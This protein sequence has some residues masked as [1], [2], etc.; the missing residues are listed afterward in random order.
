MPLDKNDL[1]EIKQLVEESQEKMARVLVREFSQIQSKFDH[2]ET[3]IG[4]PEHRLDELENKISKLEELLNRL[5]GLQISWEQF[6]EKLTEIEGRI[7]RLETKVTSVAKNTDDGLDKFTRRINSLETM[8]LDLR[9]WQRERGEEIEAIKAE[10]EKSKSAKVAQ[11]EFVVVE[12]RATNK[13]PT[14]S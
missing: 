13:A 6:Q 8:V 14:G 4:Q 9:E 7:G 11:S 2:I 3:R 10:L 12:R 1:E 5:Y